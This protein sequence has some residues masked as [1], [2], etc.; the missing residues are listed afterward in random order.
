M[1]RVPTYQTG[2]VDPAALP[3]VR[4]SSIA[5]PELFTEISGGANLVRAGTGVANAGI[6][7]L[8][9]AAD[10]QE[11][12]DIAVVKKAESEWL[13]EVSQ[14]ELEAKQKQGLNAASLPTVADEF[15]GKSQEKYIGNMTD[16][17]KRAFGLI[18]QKHAPAFRN[19][20]ATHSAAQINKAQEDSFKSSLETFQSRAA[21]NPATADQM[22]QETITTLQAWGK[23]KGLDKQ[24]LDRAITEELTKLHVG[25]ISSY[26]NLQDTDSMKSYFYAHRKEMDGQTAMKIE[27]LINKAGI[28]KEAQ[29]AADAIMAMEM[30]DQEA[31]AYIEKNYSGEREKQIKQEIRQRRADITVA[32][33]RIQ[34]ENNDKAWDI[35]NKTGS[36]KNIPQSVR[37]AMDPKMLATLKDK[38]ANDIKAKLGDGDGFPKNG[39]P[40]L[41]SQLRYAAMDNPKAFA[42]LDMRQYISKLSKTQYEALLDIQAAAK[43]G[44]D[45]KIGEVRTIDGQ[46]NATMTNVKGLSKDDKYRLEDK[47]RAA[48]DAEQKAL[49]KKLSADERQKIIDRHVMQGE[50]VQ[51]KWFKPDRNVLFYEV[52]GTPDESKFVPFIPDDEK[53]KIKA[54]LQ[55]AKRPVNDAE[56]MKLYKQKMGIK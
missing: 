38:E 29:D 27:N 26:E 14:F 16:R 2:Q 35:Y 11:K 9:F 6:A 51:G 41:Y 25:V 53:A 47:I 43:K 42:D 22:R 37:D 36:T 40:D 18:T 15:W 39:D 32:T 54:A 45:A 19:G 5:S 49:G 24:T 44:D 17:Q 1:P 56:I 10:L 52:V 30:S 12:E 4:Q 8:K 34:A 33:N 21:L 7:G 50:V 48:V 3:Q 23:I 31:Y 13:S 55:R 20:I 46:I 28:E